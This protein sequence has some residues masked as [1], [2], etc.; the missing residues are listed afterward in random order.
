MSELSL[1]CIME[2]CIFPASAHSHP[3]CY[4][5]LHLISPLLDLPIRS[6]YS[7]SY[8]HTSPASY[9]ARPLPAISSACSTSFSPSSIPPSSQAPSR[10]PSEWDSLKQWH[11]SGSPLSL[12]PCSSSLRSFS[13]SL[14]SCYFIKRRS[15]HPRIAAHVSGRP[16]QSP[17]ATTIR[18]CPAS[19]SPSPSVV[20]SSFHQPPLPLSGRLYDA[21]LS[22]SPSSPHSSSA[23]V[24]MSPSISTFHHDHQHHRHHR[25]SSQRPCCLSPSSPS[26]S[27]VPLPCSSFSALTSP[28]SPPSYSCSSSTIPHSSMSFSSSPSTSPTPPTGVGSPSS[29]IPSTSS[30]SPKPLSRCAISFNPSSS[31]SSLDFVGLISGGK[32]SIYSIHV[33]LSLGHRLVAVAALRPPP[34][35]VEADSFMFQSIGT[36]L[37]EEIAKCLQ[38]PLV[39][40]TVKGKPLATSTLNYDQ[41]E[42][43]E[44]EDLADLLQQVKK[45][46][47]SVSGVSAGAILSDYQ[48]LRVEHVCH[49]LKLLPLFYLWH[50]DQEKLLQEM[51]LWGLDAVVVKTAAWGLGK[52]HL[53]KTIRYLAPQL[54]KLH[55]DIGLHQCGEGGEYETLVVDC[56]RFEKEAIFI[57]K[58][59][60]LVHCEDAYAPVLLLQARK[61]RRR[62]KALHSLPGGCRSPSSSALSPDGSLPCGGKE[63]R[64]VTLVEEKEEQGERRNWNEG[65]EDQDAERKIAIER[66]KISHLAVVD[67]PSRRYVTAAEA[68]AETA[69]R[70]IRRGVQ[71][72]EDDEAAESDGNVGEIVYEK[73]SEAS[74]IDQETSE[75]EDRPHP[76]PLPH[77]FREEEPQE[78]NKSDVLKV[79]SS[80]PD[81]MN[82]PCSS[83]SSSC[84]SSPPT[85]S[86][87]SSSLRSAC[88]P[89][90]FLRDLISL[91][92]YISPKMRHTASY[93]V[94]LYSQSL[95]SS[96]P[97]GF[98]GVSTRV[99]AP[100]EDRSFKTNK[101][102]KEEENEDTRQR[103]IPSVHVAD[104]NKQKDVDA[105]H[106]VRGSSSS[107]SPGVLSIESSSSVYT[108]SH[109]AASSSSVIPVTIAQSPE[110]CS[111]SLSR[112]SLVSEESRDTQG[113]ERETSLVG[114][115]EKLNDKTRP[116][117]LIK[118]RKAGH[119]LFLDVYLASPTNLDSLHEDTPSSSLS[120]STLT[121]RPDPS[122]LPSP[123]PPRS[124]LFLSRKSYL[125]DLLPL[126]IKTLRYLLSI[127]EEDEAANRKRFLPLG[128]VVLLVASSTEEEE[129]VAQHLL[130][131]LGEVTVHPYTVT[132]LGLP[133]LSASVE[134]QFR[135]WFRLLI[136]TTAT[137]EEEIRVNEKTETHTR[138]VV[139][140]ERRDDQEESKVGKGSDM[141]KDTFESLKRRKKNHHVTCFYSSSPS[142]FFTPFHSPLSSSPS[143][144]T[145]VATHLRPEQSFVT[146]SLNLWVPAIDVVPRRVSLSSGQFCLNPPTLKASPISSSSLSSSSLISSQSVGAVSGLSSSSLPPP[147]QCCQVLKCLGHRRILNPPQADGEA[148]LSCGTTCR[149]LFLVGDVPGRIPHSNLLPGFPSL[150]LDERRD[151]SRKERE[152][153]RWNS[154]ERKGGPEQQEERCEKMK[155]RAHSVREQEG[156]R[157]GVLP[158]SDRV[159][160]SFALQVLFACRNLQQTL[161]L[162]GAPAFQVSKEEEEEGEYEEEEKE[163]DKVQDGE[164][165]ETED[166][167]DQDE[168][169]EGEEEEEKDE[170]NEMILSCYPPPLVFA[171]VSVPHVHCDAL[172]AQCLFSSSS[173]FSSSPPLS[174]TSQPSEL[175]G[176]QNM[177]PPQE[178]D[179]GKRERKNTEERTIVMNMERM[180]ISKKEEKHVKREDSILLEREDNMYR[181]EVS[182]VY[183]RL[184]SIRNPPEEPRGS[185]LEA[186]RMQIQ[187]HLSEDIL[188][189]YKQKQDK[190]PSRRRRKK[191]SESCSRDGEN[192]GRDESHHFLHSPHRLCTSCFLCS[193]SSI[194]PMRRPPSSPLGATPP[195][196]SHTSSSSSFSLPLQPPKDNV[197]FPSPPSSPPSSQNLLLL[198]PSSSSASL[199]FPGNCQSLILPSTLVVPLLVKS[200]QGGGHVSLWPLGVLGRKRQHQGEEYREEEKE[201]EK[202]KQG[203]SGLRRR[204]SV[205]EKKDEGIGI[206][207]R[208][209]PKETAFAELPWPFGRRFSG[210]AFSSSYFGVHEVQSFE[211]EKSSEE[212][213]DDRIG[214]RRRKRE[215]KNVRGSQ[216]AS[217]LV[218]PGGRAR[219]HWSRR[220]GLMPGEERDMELH[221][222]NDEENRSHR[223]GEEEKE[224]RQSDDGD[225]GHMK[226]KVELGAAE[227]IPR[228]VGGQA[229][230]RKQEDGN[231]PQDQEE[232]RE[233]GGEN[234]NKSIEKRGSASST[235][236]EDVCPEKNTRHSSDSRSRSNDNTERKAW[237]KERRSPRKDS[238][239]CFIV[240]TEIT[241]QLG[242]EMS[243]VSDPVREDESSRHAAADWAAAVITLG[244]YGKSPNGLCQP[245]KTSQ[246]RGASKDKEEEEDDD[247]L[248]D[249]NA[250]NDRLEEQR[251]RRGVVD[252][253]HEGCNVKEASCRYLNEKMIARHQQ[254][255]GEEEDPMNVLV[256]AIVHGLEVLRRCTGKEDEENEDCI[257]YV[258]YVVSLD[259]C[260]SSRD[261]RHPSRETPPVSSSDRSSDSYSSSSSLLSPDPA[262]PSS[263]T[264]TT[265]TPTRCL[266]RG[267]AWEKSFLTWLRRALRSR[268]DSDTTAKGRYLPASKSSRSASSLSPT[269]APVPT[270]SPSSSLSRSLFTK[271]ICKET[272][273]EEGIE[274]EEECPFPVFFLPTLG[275]EGE[276]TYAQAVLVMG[277]R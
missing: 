194:L 132:S 208:E 146:R 139:A 106:N 187:T 96:P 200:V 11:P 1:R 71:D 196:T 268:G 189:A 198:P 143:S 240:T 136:E 66:E 91:R 15:P 177:L 243:V 92:F 65:E 161:R 105:N 167:D 231:E 155:E 271:V 210:C 126:I 94:R 113:S 10:P 84:S 170:K 82:L 123:P 179:Q 108:A 193:S 152:G 12:A 171:F 224:G 169:E 27:V 67:Q 159:A 101:E 51:A 156:E 43:D 33:A 125:S 242:E 149:E 158:A 59:R 182:P 28:L 95:F 227:R 262:G 275:L 78:L 235:R 209:S 203:N 127:E 259:A 37:V 178:E 174:H 249:R 163:V 246:Q 223:K 253:A 16:H 260:I 19:I 138:V 230:G 215:G 128:H 216:V 18:P 14:S 164:N 122:S 221:V 213:E 168:D 257:L 116:S 76:L 258:L 250:T 77:R 180:Q 2:P 263:C 151:A 256:E 25:S 111:L 68:A 80:F 72:E 32:D 49:R 21:G 142:W 222:K 93:C 97:G 140:P 130:A 6:S 88:K 85:V 173:S 89:C 206:Y 237:R 239:G 202:K 232:R 42:G 229:Q 60:Y 57:E 248:D 50:R 148:F 199:S 40:A 267:V 277:G 135:L 114:E 48:R 218:L 205:E 172:S 124:H 157:H 147:L 153:T 162:A 70:A 112:R 129:E 234:K 134:G 24:S 195:H 86:S 121:R 183:E 8:C 90:S 192:A 74:E 181:D 184:H 4:H 133:S 220:V 272:E 54:K 141:P 276:G 254:R 41:T 188:T 20:S 102:E 273:E 3:G 30:S 62:P 73:P 81:V 241:A 13:S 217:W 251:N 144:C 52:Q 23:F 31:S 244:R 269:H 226:E 63:G 214:G 185:L 79:S 103:Q 22:L 236:R 107:S 190:E 207:T 166:E 120:S 56:P 265:T 150:S 110:G 117:F 131:K 53:G 29:F 154:H 201:G 7:P 204:I 228:S 165:E 145:T 252:I 270:P 115:K 9:H 247:G 160:E 35:I 225:E 238:R 36:E 175:S 55:K 197:S 46:F 274:E 245:E 38:V 87:S 119:R 266:H 212:E 17:A 104:E 191:A 176:S 211:S 98:E 58:W 64:S 109:S 47:P 137:E 118:G 100:G 255:G 186:V 219:G 233:T 69:E 34:Q 44:V 39:V 264:R 61:W 99:S 5:S 45:Q 75:T 83:C 261:Q 26:S